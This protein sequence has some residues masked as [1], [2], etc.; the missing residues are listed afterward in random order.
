MSRGASQ[1]LVESSVYEEGEDAVVAKDPDS[2]V[3][4]R[5]NRFHDIRGRK[6]DT[7]PTFEA[8][9]HYSYALDPVDEVP[10]AVAAHAGPHARHEKVGRRVRVALDRSE[11]RR[12][13]TQRR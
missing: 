11:E 4:S 7:G 2:R 6:D 8:S 10:Q 13:G 1:H 5:D 3:H 9:D 12:G